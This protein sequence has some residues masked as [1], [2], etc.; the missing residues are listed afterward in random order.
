M[1]ISYSVY[2]RFNV[3][4]KLLRI[5]IDHLQ[6]NDTQNRVIA[7]KILAAIFQNPSMRSTWEKYV[8]L[9]T[10]RILNAHSDEKREVRTHCTN[11]YFLPKSAVKKSL[12]FVDHDYNIIS[13]G[14]RSRSDGCGDG[15]LLSIFCGHN[16]MH[17]S[18]PRAD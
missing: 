11:V 1:L 4:R 15:K 12:V 17:S 10:L 3:F 7:L 14:K 18:S 8:E 13:G 5:F 9:I 6:A 2:E 16:H